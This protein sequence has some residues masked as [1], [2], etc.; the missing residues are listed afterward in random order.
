VADLPRELISE[1]KRAPHSEAVPPA[2]PEGHV[3][4][5][6]LVMGPVHLAHAAR[7]RRPSTSKREAIRVPRV[8][9]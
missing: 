7:P 9:A 2:G 4:V 8:M 1:R 6:N 5:E 3:L